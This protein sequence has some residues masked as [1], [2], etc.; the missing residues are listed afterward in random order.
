MY[1]TH[2]LPYAIVVDLD[3]STGLQTGRIL[4]SRGVP[5]IGIASNPKHF[6]C[7]TRTCERIITADT[8]GLDLIHALEELGTQLPEKAVLFPCADESVL[9]ISKHRQELQDWYHIKLPEPEVVEMLMN[10]ISFYAYAQE[11]GL[12]VPRTLLL[13]NR[14][15]AERA[16]KEFDYPCILKPSI[17]SLVWKEHIRTK[18]FKVASAEE[19][20]ATYDRCAEW[21]DALMVQQWVEGSDADHYAC[22]CYFGS[23]H[24]PLVTFITRKL[25]QWKPETGEGCLSEEVRNDV[26]LQESVRLFRGVKYQ[27]LGYVEMKQDRRTG[28]HYI[29]EPNIGRPTGRSANAEGGGVELLYTMYCDALDRPLP[30]NREQQYHGVKWIYWRKDIQSALYYWRRGDLTL[31][32]WWRS[33]RGPKVSAVFS[34]SDP[35]PFFADLLEVMKLVLGIGEKQG[36]ARGTVPQSPNQEVGGRSTSAGREQY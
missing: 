3:C 31:K 35:V 28:M 2:Q 19:F 5:V 27:G 33:W 16:A 10:K 36:R 13:H 21:T 6:C 22:N 34:W 12:P 14:N 11:A 25:R 23:D 30:A 15:E 29:I 26:V 9:L 18:A 4:H 8:K 1:S 32:E 24:E 17:K 20:L 7:R